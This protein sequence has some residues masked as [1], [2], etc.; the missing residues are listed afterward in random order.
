MH[1]RSREVLIQ[2]LD[3]LVADGNAFMRR[4][5]RIMLTNLGARSVTEVADGLTALDMI[6]D[7]D[8]GVVLLE[9]DLP[10]LGG[11]ELLRIVRSPGV[12]PRPNIPVIMLTDRAH[13][14]FVAEALRTG[15]HEYLVKPTSPKALRDRLMSVIFKPRPMMQFGE[16]YVPEPRNTQTELKTARVA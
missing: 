8:P 14:S 2:G 11:M 4:Q 16:H 9:W 12:F 5:T 7:G 13:R 10:V 15:A 3:I 1:N 6:R